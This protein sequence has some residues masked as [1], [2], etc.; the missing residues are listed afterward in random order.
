[1]VQQILLL[2][3]SH[4]QTHSAKPL[5]RLQHHDQH[6]GEDWQCLWKELPL[7]RVLREEQRANIANEYSSSDLQERRITP[8]NDSA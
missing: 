7:Q 1:M 3:E 2:C 5:Y 8:Q 4:Q 6:V